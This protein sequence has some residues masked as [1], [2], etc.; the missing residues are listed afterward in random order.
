MTL[1]QIK[2]A[3]ERVR[4]VRLGMQQESLNRL[5]E[6]GLVEGQELVFIKRAPLGDPIEIMVMDYNLSIRKSEARFIEVEP[7]ASGVAG[8]KE[9]P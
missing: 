2:K 5:A 1:D 9:K 8:L 6:L 7:V 4:I 3:N